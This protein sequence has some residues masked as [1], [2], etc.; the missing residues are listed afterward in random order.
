MTDEIRACMTILAEQVRALAE[1]AG[2]DRDRA[3]AA[4]AD[5]EA[6]TARARRTVQEINR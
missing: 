3:L 1:Q 6:A 5:I 4:L 2:G